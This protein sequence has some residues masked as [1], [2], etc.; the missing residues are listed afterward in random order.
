MA[1]GRKIAKH[2]GI[3]MFMELGVRL[4]DAL[5]SIVLARYLSPDGFG[6]MAFAISFSALYSILPGFGMGAMI[7][8]DVARNPALRNS[9]ICNGIVAKIG[10]GLIAYGLIYAVA[11]FGF[12]LPPEKMSLVMLAGLLMILEANVRFTT[13]FFQAAQRM[14]MVAGTNLAIRSGW[15]IASFLVISMKGGIFELIFVRVLLNA[16]GI[17]I[18]FI[19]MH[20][21]LGKIRWEFNFKA[22]INLLKVSFPFALFRLF[23][24][25]YADIDTVMLSAMRGDLMTGWYAAAYKFHRI[26]SFIP[27]SLFGSMLPTLTKQYANGNQKEMISTLHVIFRYL[28]AL[29]LPITAGIFMLSRPIILLIYGSEYE[30][31]VG[32][33]RI[34]IWSLNYTFLNSTLN[35]TI[36]A[37]GMEKK[38]SATLFYGALASALSNLIVIPLYGHLGAAATTVFA[39]GLIF[40][41][42][43]A[44]VRKAL[45]GLGI[46]GQALRPLGAALPMMGALYFL[47]SMPL[48]VA[49]AGGSL[50]Y[51]VGVILLKIVRP[52][53]WKMVRNGI[54]RRLTGR[55]AQEESGL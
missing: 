50:V 3:F 32:V 10:L 54:G 37:L 1:S 46:W 51:L 40:Y 31:A 14:R 21:M 5:V 26:F 28:F 52:E 41:M 49:V 30:G 12:R 39:E 2:T 16:A 43:T 13:G 42:Q 6:L 9:Y 7:T 47:R 17:V 55:S 33:M 48:P 19:L 27:Q 15:F 20:I 11:A 25:V 18:M 8:R 4:I 44:L 36:A 38:G 35:A 29:S 53:D 22:M 24:Q 23:G 45:P 34:L